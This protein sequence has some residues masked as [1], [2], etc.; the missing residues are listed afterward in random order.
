MQTTTLNITI[1]SEVTNLTVLEDIIW[2]LVVLL[3]Y[4]Q[5]ELGRTELI[6]PYLV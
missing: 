4:D 5:H 3:Y 1:N 2:L 6:R